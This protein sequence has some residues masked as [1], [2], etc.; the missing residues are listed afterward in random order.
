M[1]VLLGISLENSLIG[2]GDICQ[3]DLAGLCLSRTRLTRDYDRLIFLIID[4]GLEGVLSDHEKM[5]AWVFNWLLADLAGIAAQTTHRGAV[6][7][8]LLGVSDIEDGQSL[9]G[10][11]ADQNRRTNLRKSITL[12]LESLFD[13][14]QD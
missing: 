2:T 8:D 1:Q 7:S 3:D 6:V 10:I 11:D 12:V 9:V 4:E 5:W 13:V 14:V